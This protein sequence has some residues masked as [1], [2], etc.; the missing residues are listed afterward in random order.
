MDAELAT[1]TLV[2][3]QTNRAVRADC[4]ARALSSPP[5][6]WCTG[7]VL[8]VLAVLFVAIGAVGLD[9]DRQDARRGLAASERVG[10]MGQVLGYWAP[11][12]WPAQV[13]PSLALVR[14]SPG[15]RANSAMV[16]WPAAVAAIL[17]GWLLAWG[18]SRTLGNRAAILFGFCWFGSLA[19]MD[20]SAGA[21]LDMILGLAMLGTIDRLLT[22]GSDAI[23][24]LWASLAFLA[25]GW[26]PLLMIGLVVI[27]IGRRGS[28]FSLGLLWPPLA[29][30][31][32]WSAVTIA[33]TSVEFWA[34]AM[35]LPLTHPPAWSL[36]TSVL[37]MGLPWSPFSLLALSPSI[38][39][40]WPAER[41]GWI[42]GWLQAAL[43]SL[44]AGTFVPGLEPAARM[45]ALTGLLV[46]TAACLES[47]WDQTLGPA[48]RRAFFWLFS[49]VLTLWLIA[50]IC[51][52]FIWNLTMPYYR[53]L[54][55]VMGLLILVVIA[56]GWAALGA[57]HLRRG[58]I[59]L[60]L[61]AIGLK[62]AHWG[63]YVPEW[64]YRHSQGPWGRAI[65]QWIPRKW[66]LYTFHDW[67]D[68]FAFF[69]ARRIRQLPSP[70]FLNYLPG[71]ESRYVLLLTSEF[72]NWPDHAPAI[73]LVARFHDQSGE[74]RILAR[75]AGL[76]PV[77]GQTTPRYLP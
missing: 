61:L 13:L 51:G 70:R 36:A 33:V 72:E 6:A 40:T 60:I 55:I 27:V 14:L 5:S 16:R 44:V 12:L 42:T 52:C 64:N 53:S 49:V 20:R 4:P 35:T 30:A 58:L 34:M 43:A 39:G 73:S 8:V 26:P 48:A 22:R 46:G 21:G 68:D 66:S 29:T 74:E 59:T 1:L 10:P 38:R 67:P 63:Y 19:L 3:T 77:P 56:L 11:D 17:G 57:G 69:I 9:L 45:I 15:G 37:L 23:A 75:T 32:L 65:G 41:R 18:M 54:G 7:L 50:M 28:T 62:L 25:G 47:V 76:I 71:A 31:I 2:H 24:G